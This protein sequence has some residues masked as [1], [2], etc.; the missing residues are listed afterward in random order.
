MLEE[1]R[2]FGGHSVGCLH[3][4]NSHSWPFD[5]EGDRRRQCTIEFTS[6]KDYGK[7]SSF[8]NTE[9]GESVSW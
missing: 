8:K 5:P 2:A 9:A 7:R 6:M 1:K 3:G 4:Q